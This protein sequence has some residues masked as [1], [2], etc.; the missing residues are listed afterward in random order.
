MA[1]LPENPGQSADKGDNRRRHGRIRCD[2]VSCSIG[3]VLDLSP[4]GLR[5][6][7]SGFGINVGGLV[8]FTLNG[9][10]GPVDVRG[11]VAWLRRKL[12]WFEAG[13][14][15]VDLSPATR[16]SISEIARVMSADAA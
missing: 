16:R 13:L 12:F 1:L 2:G 11:R 10:D 7:G 15:F 3:E 14:T 8:Q 5:V 6:S 9:P 4:T